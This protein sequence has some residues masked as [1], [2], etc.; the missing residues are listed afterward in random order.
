[1]IETEDAWGSQP[2]NCELKHKIFSNYSR[3]SQ[4]S[5]LRINYLSA[6]K[7]FSKNISLFNRLLKQL[8]ALL[9]FVIFDFPI[10]GVS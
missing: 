10:G 6:L 7:A 8:F 2:K 9:S 3:H 5:W 1:M 4:S